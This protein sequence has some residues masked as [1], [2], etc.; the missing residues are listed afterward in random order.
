MLAPDPGEGSALTVAIVAPPWYPLPPDGYGGIELVVSLL[1]AGLRER[2]HRVLLFGASDSSDEV[3]GLGDSSWRRDLGVVHA[4]GLRD[5][6]YAARVHGHLAG[7]DGQIDV[8]HDHSG[9]ATVAL[10][11]ELNIAPVIHTVH[12]PVT[13][14]LVSALHSLGPWASL[15]AIS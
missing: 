4:Q 1:A 8:V 13:E 3:I 15:V 12:G 9:L 10:T 6:T 11:Q 7:V 14:P 5:L 2:G